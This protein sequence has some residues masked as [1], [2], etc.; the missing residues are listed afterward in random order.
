M[1]RFI[2][3][4]VSDSLIGGGPVWRGGLFPNSMQRARRGGKALVLTGVMPIR[5]YRARAAA[6]AGECSDVSRKGSEDRGR[7]FR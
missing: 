2:P 1:L 6:I 7:S 5:P 3:C 4:Q